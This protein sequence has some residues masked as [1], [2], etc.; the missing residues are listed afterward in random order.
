MSKASVAKLFVSF[1]LPALA[2]SL[3]AAAQ[4]ALQSWWPEIQHVSDLPVTLDS[5]AAVTVAGVL[6]IFAGRW[7]HRNVN[8]ISGV[9]AVGI[10]PIVW[11]GLILWAAFHGASQIGW[12]QP[13]TI[14]TIFAALAPAIGVMIGWTTIMATRPNLG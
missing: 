11:C 1:L 2:V 5:L 4:V 10:V 13:L 7:V 6:C 14:F 9:V 3:A 12:F 8:S